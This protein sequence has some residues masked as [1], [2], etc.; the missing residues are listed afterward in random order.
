MGRQ[1][2]Y[3]SG[4]TSSSMDHTCLAASASIAFTERAESVMRSGEL[5]SRPDVRGDVEGRSS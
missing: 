2:G 1:I 4:P 5:V 3:P